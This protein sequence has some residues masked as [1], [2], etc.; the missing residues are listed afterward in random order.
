MTGTTAIE[1]IMASVPWKASVIFVYTVNWF[2][3][4]KISLIKEHGN[5]EID[6][7]CCYY[8]SF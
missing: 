3:Q 6:G 7:L 1:K 5:N 8:Y 2:F 4:F